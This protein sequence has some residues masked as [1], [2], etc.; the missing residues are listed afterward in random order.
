MGMRGPGRLR[1]SFA[2]VRLRGAVDIVLAALPELIVAA[3]ALLIPLVTESRKNVIAKTH[4]D[5]RIR[6]VGF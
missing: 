5:N 4:F 6:D 2:V 3:S 1:L